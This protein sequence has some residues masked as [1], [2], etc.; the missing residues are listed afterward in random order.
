MQLR[1]ASVLA[2][3]AKHLVASTPGAYSWVWALQ[4]G[5]WQVESWGYYE[6][7]GFGAGFVHGPEQIK[8]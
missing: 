2:V 1:L 7:S 6:G 5:P 3:P 8:V 4:R